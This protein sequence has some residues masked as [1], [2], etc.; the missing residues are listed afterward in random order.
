MSGIF[1][2][3]QSHVNWLSQRF[4][5]SA[6]NVANSD[7]PGFRA[8]QISDFKMAL[9]NID[10]GKLPPA[11]PEDFTASEGQAESYEISHQFNSEVSHSGNDVMIEKEMATI[12]D[13]SRRLSFDTNIERMFHRMYISSL[14]G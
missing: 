1:S 2:V 7:T 3:L 14:K 5:V 8:L 4:A 9:E 12:G 11:S 6:T 13:T 10:V